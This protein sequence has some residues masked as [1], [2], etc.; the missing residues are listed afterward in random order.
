MLAYIINKEDISI[1]ILDGNRTIQNLQNRHRV[2][3]SVIEY[4][5]LMLILTEKKIARSHCEQL[6]W[7]ERV[8]S[9]TS[10]SLTQAMSTLRKKLISLHIDDL[11]IT[12][13]R[14]GYEMNPEWY[15]GRQKSQD[16]EVS[17]TPL[18]PKN[19]SIE[20]NY[21]RSKPYV[22]LEYFTQSNLGALILNSLGR[23][24]FGLFFVSIF[25]VPLVCYFYNQM[26][27]GKYRYSNSIISTIPD[28]NKNIMAIDSK[29]IFNNLL[30]NNQKFPIIY[31]SVSFDKS[32]TYVLCRSN[33]QWRHFRISHVTYTKLVHTF[34]NQDYLYQ[35]CLND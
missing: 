10:K 3:L 26:E 2:K 16:I 28:S 15:F 7:Q 34:N 6:L 11:I 24:D 5:L 32:W 33:N 13:P 19:N 25:F 8:V 17:Y 21:V 27:L 30:I 12:L 18:L 14:Y 9:D 4:Q 35:M 31:H 1:K 29:F 23:F 22:S 20:N